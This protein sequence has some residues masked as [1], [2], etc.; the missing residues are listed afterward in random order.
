MVPA[1]RPVALEMGPL[2][3]VPVLALVIHLEGVQEAELVEA[4]FG[5]KYQGL[6]PPRG[7]MEVAG[8][9]KQRILQRRNSSALQPGVLG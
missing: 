4:L 8:R 6:G 7:K 5:S 3:L 9:E 1:A 2:G